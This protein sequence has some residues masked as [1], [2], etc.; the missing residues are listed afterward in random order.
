MRADTADADVPIGLIEM[1]WGGTV[2]EAWMP[3]GDQFAC[4]G[5]LCEDYYDRASNTVGNKCDRT[6]QSPDS[7]PGSLWNGMVN[8]IKQLTIY[9]TLWY[10]VRESSRA[11]RYE[12]AGQTLVLK[13]FLRCSLPLL[14]IRARTM[15]QIQ[16]ISLAMRAMH[17]CYHR[18]C[19]RGGES[20]HLQASPVM[21]S[22]LVSSRCTDG[23]EKKRAT[24]VLGIRTALL[25]TTIH[26]ILPRSILRK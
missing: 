8:P 20:S 25:A 4:T 26:F 12:L 19:L 18:C 13:C 22:R 11:C 6:V 3:I 16:V 24:A 5:R 7:Q 15:G 17:V 1:A 9:S 21:L 2:I 23:V 10:Q 14:I